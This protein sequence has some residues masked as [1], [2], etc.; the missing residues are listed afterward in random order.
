MSFEVKPGHPQTINVAGITPTQADTIRKQIED[1]LRDLSPSIQSVTIYNRTKTCTVNVFC[2]PSHI[3]IEVTNEK[4]DSIF[5]LDE[6]P[7]TP[8]TEKESST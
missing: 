2:E 4:E 3:R 5:R 6:I 1:K 8:E 7:Q